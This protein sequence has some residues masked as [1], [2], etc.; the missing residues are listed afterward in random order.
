MAH[1]RFTFNGTLP[2][3]L[4]FQVSRPSI[5]TSDASNVTYPLGAASVQSPLEICGWSDERQDWIIAPTSI[6]PFAE[7]FKGYFC[8]R[9]DPETPQPTYGIIQ[10]TTTIPA[11]EGKV[12]TGPLLSVYAKF[13]KASGSGTV[14]TLRVGTS[15]ISEEQARA[16]LE[17]E[18]PDVST[19]PSGEQVHL[20]PGTFE[21]TAYLVRKSWADLLNRVEVQVY[22]DGRSVD[23][24]SRDFVDLQTFWTGVVHTLQ[25]S[26]LSFRSP[27]LMNSQLLPT[28]VP[29]RATRRKFILFGLR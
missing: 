18:I 17:T 26:L 28:K 9:F 20:V 6:A 16:N 5:I 8:A 25:V 1:L 11:E 14:I 4:V 12:S 13:P 29:L 3:H 23:P 2:P 24:Q 22:A 21:N 19:E 15:F 7:Q 10:N 27:S